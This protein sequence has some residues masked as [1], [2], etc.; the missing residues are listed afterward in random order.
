M[1]RHREVKAE[2][3]QGGANQVPGLARARQ[4]TALSVGVVAFA[5]S[6]YLA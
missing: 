1:V 4:T 5:R 6:D 3:L 2:Q